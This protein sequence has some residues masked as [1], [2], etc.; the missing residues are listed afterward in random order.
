M[1]TS[2]LVILLNATVRHS[3]PPLETPF[4]YTRFDLVSVTPET[5]L[6]RLV[7]A[8]KR[9]DLQQCWAPVFEGSLDGGQPPH[10]HPA[11]DADADTFMRAAGWSL[12]VY[13][14]SGPVRGSSHDAFCP[15]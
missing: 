1:A 3:S 6:T 2:C 14:L 10:P 13:S 7:H 9:S 12:G 4:V 11:T 15:I 5:T 8:Y